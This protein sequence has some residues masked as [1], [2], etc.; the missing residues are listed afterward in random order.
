MGSF[1]TS[2]HDGFQYFLTMVD[3]CS[4]VTWVYLLKQKSD[5]LQ[6]FPTNAN[7]ETQF[8]RNIKRVRSDN[9]LELNFTSFFQSKGILSF[10]SYPE[11]PQQNSVVERKH[12]HIFNVA[13][14]LFFQSHIPLSYWGD[15]IITAVH[16][17]NRIPAPILNDKSPFEILTTKIPDYSQLKVFGSLLCFYFAQ[18][19]T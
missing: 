4:R 15:C 11:T 10:H 9:A 1:S 3:E 6:V 14:S 19:H 8:Q 17:I 2:T 16:L 12:Q 13:R 5:V 7:I 18:E